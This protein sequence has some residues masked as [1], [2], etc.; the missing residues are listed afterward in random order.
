MDNR[1]AQ[2]EAVN[3]KRPVSSYVEK[4]DKLVTAQ[5][6]L[7]FVQL[8]LSILVFVKKFKKK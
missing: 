3:V 6:A 8:A 5:K 2:W 1:G 7:G 4:G